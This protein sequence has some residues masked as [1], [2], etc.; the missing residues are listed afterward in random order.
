MNKGDNVSALTKL[1]DYQ[2]IYNQMEREINQMQYNAISFSLNKERN[3]TICFH[4]NNPYE[5]C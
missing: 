5:K 1:T 4:L 2:G 3:S